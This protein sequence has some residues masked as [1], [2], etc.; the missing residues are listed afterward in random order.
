MSEI[1]AQ[2]A[3]ES[4]LL[5][6]AVS[7]SVIKQNAQQAQ[8]LVEILDQSLTSVPVSASRGANVNTSA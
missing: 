2:I 7:L 4:A 1:P 3:A 6:Q 8:R 5:R